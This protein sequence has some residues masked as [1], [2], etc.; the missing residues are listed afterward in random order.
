MDIQEKKK[1]ILVFI[2]LFSQ[3]SITIRS[4]SIDDRSEE[5]K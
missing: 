1:S 5:Q 3:P 4:Q 2:E